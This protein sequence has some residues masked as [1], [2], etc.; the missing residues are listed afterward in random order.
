MD[1]GLEFLA[2][3]AEA[4]AHWLR[5]RSRAAG[6]VPD[7]AAGS[8]ADPPALA[9]T[10]PPAHRQ[11]RLVSCDPAHQPASFTRFALPFGYQIQP[12]KEA[13]DG[14][15]WQPQDEVVPDERR[16]DVQRYFTV[17]T[18]KVLFRRARHFVLDGRPEANRSFE[19]PR[20]CG[21]GTYRVQI[22][23]PRLVLFEWPEASKHDALD[24]LATGFLL[25]DLTFPDTAN[26][27]TFDELLELNEVFRYCLPPFEGHLRDSETASLGG[28]RGLASVLGDLSVDL[29]C[30]DVST[31]KVADDPQLEDIERKL[32]LYFH[33]W[34]CL[35]ERP[36]VV[37]ERTLRL[38]PE[39][40]CGAA[41]QWLTN[42]LAEEGNGWVVYADNRVFVWS[43][44]ILE[45]GL[46]DLR[47]GDGAA[48]D[49]DATS[50]RS[51]VRFLNVDLPGTSEPSPFDQE[52]ARERTFCRWQHFGT[53]YGFSYH[54]GVVVAE[55]QEDPEIWR[56]F[57]EIYFYQTLLLLYLRVSSFRFS[58]EM[59]KISPDLR[60]ARPQALW[61]IFET[62]RRDFAV[63]TNLYQF[64]LLS[65]QQQG[66]ELYELTRKHL[67]VDALFQEVASEVDSTHRF[68]QACLTQRQ[69]QD[70][71]KLTVVA[72]VGLLLS[73]VVGFFGMNILVK[74]TFFSERWWLHLAAVVSAFLISWWIFGRTH[75]HYEGADELLELEWP[76]ASKKSGSS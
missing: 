12:W 70:A 28:R 46:D 33:R 62:F 15:R 73:V 38:Y 35:L 36:L 11:A 40:W 45:N 54:S 64:P 51:W 34:A 1:R 3:V 27:P 66:I 52:W 21:S 43:C 57:D 8:A 71:T 60:T 42:P 9:T 32:K 61:R 50:L 48:E 10:P 49:A 59:S 37:G 30:P 16:A 74:Q 13:P 67:D 2:D 63:F 53:V 6:S 55:P 26:P 44:A 18:A 72:T 7:Q 58:R 25:I 31:Q 22:Q 5:R 14:A 4:T 69:S 75:R 39:A 23:P 76:K 65:N 17:E 19:V 47:A 56:H 24:L 29:C 41:R 20:R 68:V